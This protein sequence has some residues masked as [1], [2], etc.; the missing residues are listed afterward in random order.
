MAD[1]I[2]YIENYIESS[3]TK[4]QLEII[5][6]LKLKKQNQQTSISISRH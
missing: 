1:N 2:I 6:K 3:L 4:E 5:R